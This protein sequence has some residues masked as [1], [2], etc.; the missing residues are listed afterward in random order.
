MRLLVRWRVAG[1]EHSD[2]G[3][4]AVARQ[5]GS[6]PGLG[7]HGRSEL[8]ARLFMRPNGMF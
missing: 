2:L 6:S 4:R 1:G 5:N 8:S 7:C 3:A